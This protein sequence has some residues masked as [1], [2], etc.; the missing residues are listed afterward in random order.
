MN[1]RLLTTL[2]SAIA[3]SSVLALAGQ[4]QP[5]PKA[6]DD[7]ASFAAAAAAAA[8]ERV[9][10]GSLGKLGGKDVPLV[11]IGQNVTDTTPD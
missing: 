2:T 8:P 9:K 7:V 10:L 5:S 11:V 3:L 1:A 4:T 6:Y